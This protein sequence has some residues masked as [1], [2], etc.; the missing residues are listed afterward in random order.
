M[1]AHWGQ[2]QMLHSLYDADSHAFLQAFF[3]YSVS[4]KFKLIKCKMNSST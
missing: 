3:F 1:A 4:N 2:E